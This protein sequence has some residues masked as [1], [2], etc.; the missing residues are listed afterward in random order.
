MRRTFPWGSFRVRVRVHVCVCHGTYR[1]AFS[2][3][4]AERTKKARVERRRE[5]KRERRSRE[6]SVDVRVAKN[7][8]ILCSDP[9]RFLSSDVSTVRPN[10]R[11]AGRTT[12]TPVNVLSGGSS[13]LFFKHLFLRVLSC[14]C[15][16]CS[17]SFARVFD[18]GCLV[19]R[20]QARATLASATAPPDREHRL[21]LRC[22]P[23]SVS[24]F[25]HFNSKDT[26]T[27]VLTRW[28]R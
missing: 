9:S 8:C 13:S 2:V 7:Q 3:E 1:Y 26:N 16:T 23:C 21:P 12:R 11:T 4:K 18:Y 27:H 28:I 17:I 25:T 6:R 19:L 10:G 15:I 22:I 14:A 20:H 5:R 24:R